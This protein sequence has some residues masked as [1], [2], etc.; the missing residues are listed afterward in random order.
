MCDTCVRMQSVHH[1]NMFQQF[2]L[3]DFIGKQNRVWKRVWTGMY[4]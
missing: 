3:M 2:H 1:E 4:G